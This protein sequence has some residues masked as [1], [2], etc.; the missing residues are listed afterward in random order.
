MDETFSLY[1]LPPEWIQNL[2]EEVTYLRGRY[3]T[4]YAQCEFLLAD[5]TVRVD[6]RFRYALEKRISA[7][8]IM[9]DS[10]GKL[11]A[12]ANELLP[13]LEQLPRYTEKRHWLA[14]GLLEIAHTKAGDHQLKLR[15]YVEG[16]KELTLAVW[17]FNIGQLRDD[18][19]S[20][21]IYGS[22][23]VDL[24]RRIYLELDLESDVAQ[25]SPLA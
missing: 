3:L 6:N 5:L 20:I 23:F 4:S 24:C 2:A 8:K 7:T 11:N 1:Q 25:D 19:S 18:V 13:L 17:K 21:T 15:R 10:Q 12:Y 9:A 22:T 14:H 16:N